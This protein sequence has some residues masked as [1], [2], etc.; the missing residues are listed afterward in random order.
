MR[1]RGI[2]VGLGLQSLIANVGLEAGGS[3]VHA[4]RTTGTWLPVAAFFVMSVPLLVG[5]V[6]GRAVLGFD[7]VVLGALTST[8]ALDMINRQA[9]RTLPTVGYAGTYA[10]A[11]VLLAIAG[12]VLMRCP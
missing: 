10:C 2:P 3:V 12:S 8:P 4:L 7:P 11:N 1:T 9:G 6:V 5:F